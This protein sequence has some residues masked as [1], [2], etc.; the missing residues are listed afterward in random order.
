VQPGWNALLDFEGDQIAIGFPAGF[1]VH[2]N[3]TVFPVSV[4]LVCA[5]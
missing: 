2:G 3:G 5:D 1:V 4:K